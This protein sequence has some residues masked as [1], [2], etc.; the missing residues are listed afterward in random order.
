MIWH[1]VPCSFKV[2]PKSRAEQII[3]HLGQIMQ[4]I[5]AF[6]I[7]CL[8]TANVTAL[9]A[10]IDVDVINNNKKPIINVKTNLPQAT[11][12]MMSISS[13]VN[14]GGSGYFG[15]AQAVVSAESIAKFGPFTKNGAQLPP[16]IYQGTVTTVMAGLQS[17]SVQSIIGVHGELITGNQT[18]SL[19]GTSERGAS[20]KFEFKID[21]DIPVD[22]SSS[23]Q[24]TIGSKDDIWKTFQ[25][26]GK[27]IFVKMNGFYYTK[28]K[29]SGIGF[30]THIVSNL[31]DSNIVGAPKSIMHDVEGN[32]EKN[33]FHILGSLFFAEKNRA[34]VAMRQVPAENI[35]RKL[36]K[37]SPFEK[38]FNELCKIAKSN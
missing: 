14:N 24:N 30:H 12:L 23:N 37:D 2:E 9:E 26:S 22:K 4:K 7:A 33:T 25:S 34:G 36:V 21:A 6:T 27:E 10:T 16:G 5:T 17:Q 35:E 8:I 20:Q 32:C 29:Y 1:L 13:P 28:D 18:Y 19:P 31:P 3:T 15:E 38:A 11:S